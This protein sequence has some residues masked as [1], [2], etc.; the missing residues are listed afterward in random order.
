MYQ[1][2]LS[3]TAK[4]FSTFREAEASALPRLVFAATKP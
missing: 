1:A 2:F 4:D 3:S